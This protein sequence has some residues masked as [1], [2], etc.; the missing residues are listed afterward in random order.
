[1][2]LLRQGEGDF[3]Q[4]WPARTDDWP[5]LFEG[6][7]ERTVRLGA[8]GSTQIRDN[9]DLSGHAGLH[10]IGNRFHVRGQNVTR[11][12]GGVS[13]TYHFGRQLAL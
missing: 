4:R 2:T 9:L 6:V 10:F 1:V 12:V 7:V 11:F 8:T 13:V 3:H 5:A